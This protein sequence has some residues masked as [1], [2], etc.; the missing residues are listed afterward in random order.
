[1]IS[2]AILFRILHVSAH[3][4][5]PK[6]CDLSILGHGSRVLGKTTQRTVPPLPLMASNKRPIV[7]GRFQVGVIRTVNEQDGF[8][9]LVGMGER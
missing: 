1:M 3:E 9:D 2:D 5:A 4:T 6:A 7:Q 8:I